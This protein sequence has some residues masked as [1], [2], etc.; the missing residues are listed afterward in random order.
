MDVNGCGA[1]QCRGDHEPGPHR[2]HD[3]DGLDAV[4]AG[5]SGD[6]RDA[7][8]PHRCRGRSVAAV[9]VG[10]RADARDRAAS[11]RGV[12][13][14]HVPGVRRARVGHGGCHA[15]VHG[16]ARPHSAWGLRARW[17]SSARSASRWRTA[18]ADTAWRGRGS[19]R[20]G[21][22]CSPSRGRAPST[23]SGC[24]TRSVRRLCWAG[25]ILLTQRAGDEVAG[26]MRLAVSMPVAGLAATDGGRSP[27][28]C[29]G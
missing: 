15:A 12:H 7:D 13:L 5:R 16:R 8:R 23:R 19:R 17:N 21:S 9:G 18:R 6:R 10:R 20:S 26:S 22:C 27:R 14:G 1:V 11:R 25:Y 29:R 3:G 28:C 4:R 2:R 24:C